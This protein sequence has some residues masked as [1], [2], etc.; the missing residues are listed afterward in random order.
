MIHFN[1]HS[2]RRY[3]LRYRA[4]R[5][6]SSLGFARWRQGR[7]GGA[8]VMAS[9]A[10]LAVSYLVITNLLATRGY[11]IQA[12]EQQITGLEQEVERLETELAG[13]QSLTSLQARLSTLGMVAATQVKY[14]SVEPDKAVARR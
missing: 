3:G 8:V 14:L 9:V 6:Y 7:A 4:R 12:L 2:D 11:Q 1:H 5:W 13:A 10:V